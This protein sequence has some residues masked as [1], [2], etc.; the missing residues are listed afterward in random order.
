MKFLEK[1]LEQIIYDADKELL[2]EKGF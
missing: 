1:D 2:A